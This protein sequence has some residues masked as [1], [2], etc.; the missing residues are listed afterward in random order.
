M[1]VIPNS[2]TLTA[3]QLKAGIATVEAS[4][5]QNTMTVMLAAGGDTIDL[6]AVA[7]TGWTNQADRVVVEGGS[8][9]D[10]ITAS[11]ASDTLRGRGGNDTFRIV[12]PTHLASGEVVEG[13]AGTNDRLVLQQQS[14]LLYTLENVTLTGVET[15]EFAGNDAAKDVFVRLTQDQIGSGA[16]STIIGRGGV[17]TNDGITVIG[18]TIDVS[19]LTLSGL[20]VGEDSF[21]LQATGNVTLMRGS[22]LNDII[23]LD[24]TNNLAVPCLTAEEGLTSSCL[25]DRR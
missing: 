13:G 21:T 10:V 15:L 14:G 24:S 22:F 18:S 20:D 7:F 5:T 6:S 17:G 12:N 19:G 4:D 16:L 23:S 25:G 9:V 3:A 11:A 1:A 8:G 2:L